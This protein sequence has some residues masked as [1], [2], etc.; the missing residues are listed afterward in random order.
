MRSLSQ[1]TDFL[2]QLNINQICH[3]F[4]AMPI[5]LVALMVEKV[6]YS[7]FFPKQN[8]DMTK[9]LENMKEIILKFLK[10]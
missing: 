9:D 2:Y 6:I 8:P 3:H 5:I 10:L 7:F 4:P 1:D